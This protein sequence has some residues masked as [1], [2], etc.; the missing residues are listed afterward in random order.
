MAG[1]LGI[2]VGVKRVGVAFLDAEVRISFPQKPFARSTAVADLL[3]LVTAKGVKEMV[4]GLP[5]T[6]EGKMTPQAAKVTR[7]V[8]ELLRRGLK[9][10]IRYV[11]EHLSSEDAAER[12]M[13]KGGSVEKAR[14]SG[15]LDCVVAALLLEGY[16]N[17][18]IP[19]VSKAVV[20]SA[21]TAKSR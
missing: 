10:D 7:F 9:C 17:G 15:E 12:I 18:G 20:A 4:V 8:S 16:I 14:R 1:Y 13:A 6:A 19:E 5:L 21:V 2:D 3:S 11:D